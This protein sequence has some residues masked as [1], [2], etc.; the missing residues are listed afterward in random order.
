MAS[1]EGDPVAVLVGHPAS[2]MLTRE[3]RQ[4]SLSSGPAPPALL[5]PYPPLDFLRSLLESQDV[6]TFH[7]YGGLGGVTHFGSGQLLE[8]PQFF[9]LGC[10]QLWGETGVL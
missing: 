7:H 9:L 1:T 3:A 10:P 6:N 4:A 8:P 5:V 2:R